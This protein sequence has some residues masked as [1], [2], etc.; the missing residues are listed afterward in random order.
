MTFARGMR[1]NQK[2]CTS[3]DLSMNALAH[4][5]SQTAPAHAAQRSAVAFT[6]FTSTNNRGLLHKE[7]LLLL[8]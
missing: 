1:G 6:N 4:L 2:I 7:Q 5:R 3:L 8:L